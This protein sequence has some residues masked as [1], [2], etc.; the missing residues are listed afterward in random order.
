MR[1]SSLTTPS[2]THGKGLMLSEQVT[3]ESRDW[4]SVT[5]NF[6][7]G[8]EFG[9]AGQGGENEVQNEGTWGQWP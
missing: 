5:L 9:V 1:G 7:S 4:N 3:G 2:T 8:P 6:R